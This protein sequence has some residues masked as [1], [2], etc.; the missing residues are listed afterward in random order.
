MTPHGAGTPNVGQEHFTTEQKCDSHS[1]N[2]FPKNPVCFRDPPSQPHRS[3]PRPS[4]THTHLSVLVLPR[5]KVGQ[6]L[7]GILGLISVRFLV[8]DWHV[9]Q[10]LLHVGLEAHV[11]HAVGLVQHHVGAAAQHQ[12]PVLQHID[13]PARSGNDDLGGQEGLVGAAQG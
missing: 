6:H 8:G 5:L 2:P 1:F 3:P 11:N 10:D 7:L 12:V 4:L 13:E 9:L